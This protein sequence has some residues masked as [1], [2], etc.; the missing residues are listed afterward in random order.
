MFSNF[1]LSCLDVCQLMSR[2]YQSCGRAS[3]RLFL[4]LCTSLDLLPF[5]ISYHLPF[6]P[7][8]IRNKPPQSNDPVRT[9]GTRDLRIP[10]SAEPYLWRP[11]GSVA[12]R[13]VYLAVSSIQKTRNLLSPKNP[14][15]TVC[16]LFLHLAI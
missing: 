3:V 15:S 10:A 2:F 13:A 14:L 12:V 8:G 16:I 11:S 7:Y 4:S 9:F 1:N 5:T 6:T